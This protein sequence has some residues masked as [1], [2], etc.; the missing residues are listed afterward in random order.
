M[1][2]SVERLVQRAYPVTSRCTLPFTNPG[3]RWYFRKK[4]TTVLSTKEREEQMIRAHP[5]FKATAVKD[6]VLYSA[7]DYGVPRITA[8]PT[9]ELKPFKTIGSRPNPYEKRVQLKEAAEAAARAKVRGVPHVS[10]LTEACGHVR[11]IK[12]ILGASA[13]RHPR[14]AC[15]PP[16]YLHQHAWLSLLSVCKRVLPQPVLSNV[17]HGPVCL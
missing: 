11:S 14:S 1:S 8:K 6:E 2:P 5:K 7:G 3:C 4:Q 13:P 17:D 9:T 16:T 12:P 15:V 10:A